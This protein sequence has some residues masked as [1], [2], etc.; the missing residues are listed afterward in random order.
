M[1]VVSDGRTQIRWQRVIHR[2]LGRTRYHSIM[3]FLKRAGP[4]Q[5]P[6]RQS[7]E[8]TIGPQRLLGP[9]K[10]WRLLGSGG[11]RGP[12]WGSRR[13][14]AV[15]PWQSCHRI[16]LTISRCCEFSPTCIHLQKSQRRMV[17]RKHTILDKSLAPVWT[18]W[19]ISRSWLV[20]NS[21]RS[22][23]GETAARDRTGRMTR[24]RGRCPGAGPPPRWPHATG[25][26]PSP[27]SAIYVWRSEAPRRDAQSLR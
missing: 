9:S 24:V 12:L 22:V 1:G 26:R 27:V 21:T 23:G 7:K 20:T 15:A 2:H 6:D 4:G 3:S 19:P 13:E 25:T 10:R 8:E 17:R 18:L 14:A 5:S 11:R 16:S